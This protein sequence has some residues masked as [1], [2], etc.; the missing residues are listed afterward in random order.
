MPKP[1]SKRVWADGTIVNRYMCRGCNTERKARYRKSASGSVKYKEAIYKSMAKYP[2]K[3]SARSKV[4]SALANGSIT[5][6]GTCSECNTL[7]K[8]EAH[9]KDYN[10]PLDVDWLC[11]QCHAGVHRNKVI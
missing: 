8:V 3:V 5:K 4:R 6:P 9:H 1:Y 7:V 11:R 10:K 2:D